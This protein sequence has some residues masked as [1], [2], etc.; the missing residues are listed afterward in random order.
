[1]G[2]SLGGDKEDPWSVNPSPSRR[3]RTDP[4]EGYEDAVNEREKVRGKERQK[5]DIDLPVDVC[6]K[7]GEDDVKMGDELDEEK[8]RNKLLADPVDVKM[9][10][11]EAV[12]SAAKESGHNRQS[13]SG[14]GGVADSMWSSRRDEDIDNSGSRRRDRAPRSKPLDWGRSST[15]R[16]EDR[17]ESG[18]RRDDRGHWSPLPRSE[19]DDR[20]HRPDIRDRDSK[21][22]SD[23]RRDNHDKDS[24]YRDS[25]RSYRLR[26]D[27]YSSRANHT[28][29]S[30]GADSSRNK[31]EERDTRRAQKDDNREK[32][33]GTRDPKDWDAR[34]TRQDKGDAT[35]GRDEEMKD[36]IPTTNTANPG[37]PKGDMDK[38][39]MREFKENKKEMCARNADMDV[40][41]STTD[42][43]KAPSH[44][45][46]AEEG[47]PR[48]SHRGEEERPRASHDGWGRDNSRSTRGGDDRQSSHR[49][50]DDLK[51]RSR[52]ERDGGTRSERDRGSGR[53]IDRD[54][55]KDRGTWDGKERG[56]E[57]R[58]RDDRENERSKREK[59]RTWEMRDTEKGIWHGE[60]NDRDR[61]RRRTKQKSVLSI[62]GESKGGRQTGSQR[63]ASPLADT[64]GM[65]APS[66]SPP[67]TEA[68]GDILKGEEVSTS[69]GPDTRATTS[70]W[71]DPGG[72]DNTAGA[73]KRELAA[74]DPDYGKWT[75]SKPKPGD[76]DNTAHS[77]GWPMPGDNENT[78]NSGKWGLA[79]ADPDYG[80]WTVSKPTTELSDAP[81]GYVPTYSGYYSRKNDKDRKP[82]W[83]E[84][85]R[86][87]GRDRPSRGRPRDN[88]VPSK[89]RD[90]G[91]SSHKKENDK[92]K[93]KEKSSYAESGTACKSESSQFQWTGPVECLDPAG[94]W[95]GVFTVTDSQPQWTGP[96]ECVDPAGDWASAEPQIEEGIEPQETAESVD[97]NGDGAELNTETD[98]QLQWTGPVECVDPAGDWASAELQIQEGEPEPYEYIPWVPGVR[99]GGRGRNGRGRVRGPRVRKK[100]VRTI[101]LMRGFQDDPKE[102]EDEDELKPEGA[103]EAA[104]NSEEP[105]PFWYL[106]EGETP[107]DEG[108]KWG[109]PS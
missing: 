11:T 87:S 9:E 69:W 57:M 74:I 24:R 50:D 18:R 67:S 91:W 97:P 41:P 31:R 75:V 59:P 51:S 63:G 64:L 21:Y 28:R 43:P 99:G 33:G 80:K 4:P 27:K 105:N 10:T 52:W 102:E 98:S 96:V 38:A 44:T 93:S 66:L 85:S 29:E 101:G 81:Q 14:A 73:S 2:S 60:F 48:S 3:A 35:P 70:G 56:E 104:T 5:M 78:A 77:S 58:S 84:Q 23:S 107:E 8:L 46:R 17:P 39:T 103:T 25:E 92:W 22:S 55:E 34:S 15:N 65:T 61:D 30:G 37:E 40:D 19:R 62:D 32:E 109:I 79:A 83:S 68:Q 108:T 90:S 7:Q 16:H 53:R 45:K 49:R 26:D 72:E 12:D 20:S 76:E 42:E 88:W 89:T 6:A 94:D 54:W 82:N 86:D 13:S 36:E 47:H 95:A 106:A 1:V 100:K 71:P